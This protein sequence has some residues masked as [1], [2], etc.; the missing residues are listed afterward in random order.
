[1][2]RKELLRKKRERLIEE[3]G[4]IYLD[5][6]SKVYSSCSPALN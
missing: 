6:F 1:M 3:K 5:N 2:G 4:I